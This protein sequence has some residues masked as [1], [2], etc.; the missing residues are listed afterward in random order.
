MNSVTHL[1][2]RWCHDLFKIFLAATFQLIALWWH[3]T[4]EN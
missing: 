4:C 3:D 2:L 1:T